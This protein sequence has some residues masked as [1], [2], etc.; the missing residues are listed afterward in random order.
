MIPAPH[1]HRPPLLSLILH[2]NLPFL[3]L[4]FHLKQF[5]ALLASPDSQG[6]TGTHA[7]LPLS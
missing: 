7:L 3:L 4:I 2:P 6:L 5:P 1:P